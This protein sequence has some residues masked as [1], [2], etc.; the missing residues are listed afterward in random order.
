MFR[1]TKNKEIILKYEELI[2]VLYQ[3]K[4]SRPLNGSILVCNQPHE[5]PDVDRKGIKRK[6]SHAAM[7]PSTKTHKDNHG[8]DIRT[9][10]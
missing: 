4:D 2:E 9:F 8:K 1:T 6:R 5:L 3:E 10:F 7:N